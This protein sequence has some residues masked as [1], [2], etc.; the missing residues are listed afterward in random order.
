MC[1]TAQYICSICQICC[2][3]DRALKTVWVGVKWPSNTLL[4]SKHDV[5]SVYFKRTSVFITCKCRGAFNGRVMWMSL[6]HF[7]S[8]LKCSCL[9][10]T[11]LL[12]KFFLLSFFQYNQA[13]KLPIRLGTT[14][15]IFWQEQGLL[16]DTISGMGVCH[17]TLCLLRYQRRFYC[18][19]KAEKKFSTRYGRLACTQL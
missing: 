4:T 3:A 5:I 6:K 16:F 7:G 2:R 14:A 11:V 12:R 18:R 9:R 10:A 15:P 17:P 8:S 19:R 1:G 13:M